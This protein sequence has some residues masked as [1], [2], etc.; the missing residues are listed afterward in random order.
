MPQ[1]ERPVLT[2][3]DDERQLRVEADGRD[4]VGMSLQRLDAGLGLVVPDLD[5]LV[6][7]A[8]DQVR[9]VTTWRVWKSEV[10]SRKN[11]QV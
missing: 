1:L 6:V 8:G 10:R 9:T 5:Q 11:N 7:S 4:V 3:A 2:S